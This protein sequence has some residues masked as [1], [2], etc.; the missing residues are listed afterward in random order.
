ME[1]TQPVVPVAPAQNPVTPPST[2]IEMPKKSGGRRKFFILGVVACV[3]LLSAVIVVAIFTKK[4]PERIPV[5][6]PTPTVIPKV[7]KESLV[8]K[9]GEIVPVPNSSIQL[10][11]ID[12]ETLSEDCAD[13]IVT[14]RIKVLQLEKEQILLYACGGIA[15][16]CEL[17]KDAFEYTIEISK[18]VGESIDVVVT[19]K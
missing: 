4:V 14:T 15:G 11:F 6:V 9:K 1:P 18:N 2:A 7:F 8:L 3:V 19:E 13:C 10:A 16:D 17:K 5:A 12:R